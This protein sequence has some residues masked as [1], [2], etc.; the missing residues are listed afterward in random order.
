MIRFHFPD[1]VLVRVP[2]DIDASNE[3]Q[4]G[5]KVDGKSD[6]NVAKRESPSY[7]SIHITVSAYLRQLQGAHSSIPYHKSTRGCVDTMSEPA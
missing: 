6:D 3:E 5:A 4:R 1:T 2:K 7:V